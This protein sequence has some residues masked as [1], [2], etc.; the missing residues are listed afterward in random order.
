M[1][2]K[3]F[4]FKKAQKINIVGTNKNKDD[5]AVIRFVDEFQNFKFQDDDTL[6]ILEPMVKANVFD[7]VN[8]SKL[9]SKKQK[10]EK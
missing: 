9:E 3:Q 1:S 7:Y 8:L 4:L 10:L 6:F 2:M 5:F